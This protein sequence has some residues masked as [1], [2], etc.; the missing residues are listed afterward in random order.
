MKL[1]CVSSSPVKK[2][3]NEHLAVHMV[4][5]AEKLGCDTELFN[6]SGLTIKPCAHCNGCIGR[7]KGG[8]DRPLHDRMTEKSGILIDY[9]TNKI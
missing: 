9:M 3:N 6:L 4:K 1:I 8:R 2:G 5:T 7:Q